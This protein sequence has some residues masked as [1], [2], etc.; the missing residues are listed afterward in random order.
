MRKKDK[1]KDLALSLIVICGWTNYLSIDCVSRD[2][3]K[4]FWHLQRRSSTNATSVPVYWG[5]IRMPRGNVRFNWWGLFYHLHQNT[6]THS[7]YLAKYNACNNNC[8]S[9]KRGEHGW[10]IE[11]FI[12]D[13]NNITFYVLFNTYQFLY[14]RKGMLTFFQ[15]NNLITICYLSSTT[16]WIA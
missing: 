14:F 15:L 12:Y 7:C 13:S 5:I 2:Y 3:N 16:F 10:V 1:C 9:H 4:R 11:K 8:H 6:C